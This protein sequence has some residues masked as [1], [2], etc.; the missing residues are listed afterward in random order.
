MHSIPKRGLS[1]RAW[2][3][4]GRD[5]R[6]VKVKCGGFYLLDIAEA[7]RFARELIAAADDAEAGPPG[8]A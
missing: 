8:I 7:R 1:A 3:F 2:P 5:E 4:F 6:L